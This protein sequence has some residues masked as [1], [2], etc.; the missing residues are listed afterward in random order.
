MPIQTR[1]QAHTHLHFCTEINIHNLDYV[2]FDI[3]EP[4]MHMQ[5]KH[6]HTRTE[7][8][9]IQ[10][11][12]SSKWYYSSLSIFRFPQCILKGKRALF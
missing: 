12:D 10:I 3:P 2:S 11:E 6:T 5:H 9:L 1:T 8:L 4:E 7:H